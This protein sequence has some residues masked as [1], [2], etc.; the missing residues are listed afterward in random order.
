MTKQPSIAF[1]Y[2]T[3]GETGKRNTT[4][5]QARRRRV[6]GSEG[7]GMI[8]EMTTELQIRVLPGNKSLSWIRDGLR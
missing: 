8:T 1:F 6:P 5:G 3:M 4:A 7:P 2:Q